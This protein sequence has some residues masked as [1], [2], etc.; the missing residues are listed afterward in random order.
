MY[1]LPDTARLFSHS[2]LKVEFFFLK[3]EAI[4]AHIHAHILGSYRGERMG[5]IL[6]FLCGNYTFFL[7]KNAS[8]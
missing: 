2:L 4:S 5:A 1:V 3:L 7:H 6:K 8:D